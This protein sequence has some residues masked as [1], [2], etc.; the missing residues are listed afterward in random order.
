[1][2]KYFFDILLSALL[3][4][5]LVILFAKSSIGQNVAINQNGSVAHS[6]AMLDVSSTSK[7]ILIPRMTT[8]QRTTISSP[9]TG[10]LVFDTDI[11]SFLFYNGSAWTFLAPA[12][13]PGGNEW[14]LLGNSGTNPTNN[15]V[16]T[17]DD[18]PLNFRINNQHS[19]QLDISGNVFYGYKAGIN[20]LSGVKNVAIGASSLH[21]NISTSRL[22]AIGDS[23][24]FSNTTG[25]Q[26][27]AIGNASMLANTTGGSNTAVGFWA[28]TNNQS[29]SQ[30]SGMGNRALSSNE[31]GSYNSAFGAG[32]LMVH[33]Y[34][35]YNTAVGG[36][37]LYKDTS[38]NNNTAIG[39]KA[40]N[41]NLSGNDNI[42]IGRSSLPG[43][44]TGNSNIAIGTMALHYNIAGNRLIA[45]G[46]SALFFNNLNG[47]SAVKNSAVGSKALYNNQ[48]GYNNNAFGFEGLKNNN[49][50][51]SNSAFGTNALMSN[52]IG[53]RNSAFGDQALRSNTQGSN[54][55]AL[56]DSSLYS[57]SNGTNNTSLGHKAMFSNTSGLNN[58]GVGVFSLMENLNGQNNVAI[59]NSSL[60]LNFDGDYN[61]AVGVDALAQNVSGNRNTAM[62][63]LALN[64]NI[65]GHSNTA[66][67]YKADVGFPGLINATAI[68]ANARA[69]DDNTLI[70]GSIAGVNS[71]SIS[72][73]VGIGTTTPYTPLHIDGGFD[74][75]YN[76]GTGYLLIGDRDATNVIYDDNEILARNN[77]AASPLYLQA[78]GG[79]VKIG[80]T[81]APT[82]QLEL[83]LNSAGKPGS[84]TWSIVSDA[85]LKKDVKDF[86]DGLSVIKQINPVWFRYNGEA[87]IKDTAQ[88]VGIL[89]QDIKKIAPYMVSENKHKDEKG[90]ETNYL[91]YD[92]NAMTYILINAIK[93]L[94]MEIEELKK[95][96][97]KN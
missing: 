61:S 10:L 49:S 79:N 69:D 13:A 47:T 40:L 93:E 95:K 41:E 76:G 22:V 28:L 37:A 58:T 17:T 73:R 6:S 53:N 42:A 24:L 68:G 83:S 14:K 84:N 36:E 96:V 60:K 75:S 12:S 94:Q 44:K 26:N 18:M 9:A 27:T 71:A 8:N 67:G 38:G 46:D 4:V 30:N 91:N 80:G 78:N 48:F 34:G 50:G 5:F 77:G 82:Y 87:G 21:S 29:G 57:N 92:G 19:G 97:N 86:K 66:I 31:T 2:K 3:T 52:T 43:N 62:G 63:N 32:S 33:R 65:S 20:N 90:I 56:G 35:S 15:F 81:E 25:A 72:A 1:M 59:G 51:N 55:S 23:S 88:F 54:N 16:G 74:A 39:Y 89:A 11:N 45:I 85:R 7:G 64:G 70:L